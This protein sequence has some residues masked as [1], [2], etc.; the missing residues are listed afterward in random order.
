MADNTLNCPLSPV[1]SSGLLPDKPEA[2]ASI[3]PP[4]LPEGSV[5]PPTVMELQQMLGPGWF[6]APSS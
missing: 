6:I 5:E 2:V 4:K 1:T 3:P